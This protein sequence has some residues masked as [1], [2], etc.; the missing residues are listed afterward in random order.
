[1]SWDNFEMLS[2]DV[3][4]SITWASAGS[5]GSG[6]SYFGCTAPSPIFVCG[7]DPHGMSRVDPDVRAGKDIRIGRYGFAHL[8]IEDD[9][10]KVKAAARQIWDRFVED[11]QIAL[12]HVRT[13]LWDREDLAWALLRFA[14]FGGDKNVGSKTGQLDYGDLNAEYVGLI[15]LA[16][17]HGVNLGLLRGMGEEWVSKF[18]PQKAMMERH[19]TGKLIPEGFKTVPDHVD[20]TLTHR[21]DS[22]QRDYV[23]RIGKF[24]NKDVKDQECPNLT[25]PMMASLAFPSTT[26]DDWS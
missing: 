13:V 1:M 21:W 25:F 23:T 14:S 9:R 7:F 2:T 3:P 11:Y 4:K 16:K 19:N 8:K 6:K 10:Q 18:N 15:Q 5:D 17:D 12:K 26:E 24:S 20:V 22:E